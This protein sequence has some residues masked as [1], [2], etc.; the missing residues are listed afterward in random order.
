MKKFLLVFVVLI[1]IFFLTQ[2]RLRIDYRP[3]HCLN[4]Q[5]IP[6]TIFEKL[7][8]F[9]KNFSSEIGDVEEVFYKQPEFYPNWKDQGIKFYLREPS[10]YVGVIGYGCYPGE[11]SKKAQANQ[12]LSFIFFIHTGWCVTKYQGMSLDLDYK[13]EYFDVKIEPKE[14]L[15]EPTCPIFYPNWTQK[16]RVNVFVN[17]NTVPGKYFINI[18]AVNPPKDIEEKWLNE[19]K[20]N[21][22]QIGM[23]SIGRPL[24]QISLE[25]E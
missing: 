25:I 10:P 3:K 4:E 23:V 8:P 20:K 14:I 9:P 12:S 24:C 13:K 11:I 22:T 7:P 19:F 18:T 5:C 16:V 2:F 21:Y 17:G 15:L 6:E 1:L